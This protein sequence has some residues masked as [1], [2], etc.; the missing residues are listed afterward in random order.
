MDTL[1]LRDWKIIEK[2][3]NFLLQF[4]ITEKNALKL[5]FKSEI[6]K[7]LFNCNAFLL[8]LELQVI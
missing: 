8:R 1:L 2:N 6:V 5:Y 4:F 3:V 7:F